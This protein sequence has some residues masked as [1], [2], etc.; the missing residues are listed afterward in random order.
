MIVG[1]ASTYITDKLIKIATTMTNEIEHI[2]FSVNIMLTR[3][4]SAVVNVKVRKANTV[5][6]CWRTSAGIW[7]RSVYRSRLII[8]TTLK[9]DTLRV[10]PRC[11]RGWKASAHAALPFNHQGWRLVG[12]LVFLSYTAGR[13]HDIINNKCQLYW[14]QFPCTCGAFIFNLSST[15][16]Y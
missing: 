14:V 15:K 2:D 12:L 8:K 5:P 1:F 3:L 13:Q 4:D 11:W 10:E 6:Y 9:T 16:I 7:F